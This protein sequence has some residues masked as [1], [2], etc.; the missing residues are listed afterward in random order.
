MSLAVSGRAAQAAC[1]SRRLLAWSAR[2]RSDN[3][4]DGQYWPNTL[5]K[6]CRQFYRAQDVVA[7]VNQLEEISFYRSAGLKTIRARGPPLWSATLLS[8]TAGSI[9]RGDR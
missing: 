6:Q 1:P 3:Q 8:E 9:G 2:P 4:G 7:L 5:L